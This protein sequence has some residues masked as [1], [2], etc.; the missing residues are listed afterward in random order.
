MAS[1]VI[2]T[3]TTAII[4]TTQQY[5]NEVKE[6]NDLEAYRRECKNKYGADRVHFHYREATKE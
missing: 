6:V 5:H 4:G 2:I 1:K 3:R